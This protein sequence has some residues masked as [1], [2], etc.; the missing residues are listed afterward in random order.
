MNK[1]GL[2]RL[3]L[4]VREEIGLGPHDPLDPLQLADA[5]GIDVLPL[6]QLGC[7]PTVLAHFQSA[8][9]SVFSGALVPLSDGSTVIVENDTH[10]PERRVS[11][12]SHE[13]AHV[14]LEHP[15]TAT[16]M[17]GKGCRISEP[18]HEAEAAEL[19]GELLIPTDAARRLAYLNVADVDVARRFGVSVEMARWRMTATGARKV[20]ARARAKRAGQR[21]R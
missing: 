9:Q 10:A 2:K 1:A 13:M 17:D 4:E 19:G 16:L 5:Y 14:I 15:F 7:S 3:A 8:R 20:A 18:A 6:S 21:A 11:T 12:A